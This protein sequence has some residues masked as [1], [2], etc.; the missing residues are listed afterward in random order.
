MIDA[1]LLFVIGTLASNAIFV[2]RNSYCHYGAIRDDESLV[3]FAS[4]T[5]A[6]N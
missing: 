6:A 3:T 5:A 2:L 4:S 1:K